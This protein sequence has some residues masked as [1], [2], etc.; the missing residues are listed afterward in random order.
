MYT[1][2]VTILGNIQNK[3]ECRWRIYLITWMYVRTT[4]CD[5][6]SHECTKSDGAS[7]T[8]RLIQN[9]NEENKWG[10]KIVPLKSITR[11]VYQVIIE[12]IQANI[13]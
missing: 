7:E 12:W 11:E 8:E 13:R 3:S 4:A 1:F 6:T 9:A 2:L 10:I 5:A